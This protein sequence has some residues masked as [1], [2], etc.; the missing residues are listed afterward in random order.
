MSTETDR[1]IAGSGSVGVMPG[2]TTPS[3]GR[4][5]PHRRGHRRPD[6]DREHV[7]IPRPETPTP[8]ETPT[9]AKLVI[10]ALDCTGKPES[11]TIKNVGGQAADL[12]KWF[13]HD[14]GEKHEYVFPAGTSIEPGA[15]VSVWTWTGAAQ[16]TFFWTGRAVWNNSGDTAFLL[17]PSGTVVNQRACF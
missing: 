9:P 17:N 2:V 6:V 12:G 15:T 5:V 13:I 11:V 3:T 14:E 1:P 16:R 8:T 7:L 4:F 10:S